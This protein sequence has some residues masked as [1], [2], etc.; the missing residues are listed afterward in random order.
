[1]LI[2]GGGIAKGFP[3]LKGVRGPPGP[4]G[5]IGEPGKK[6]GKLG[7]VLDTLNTV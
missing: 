2:L 6:G 3:T 4:A 1:M 5:T 7:F